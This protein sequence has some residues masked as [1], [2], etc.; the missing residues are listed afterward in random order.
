MVDNPDSGVDSTSSA[1]NLE[2]NIDVEQENYFTKCS[3]GCICMAIRIE[4]G[5][6]AQLLQFYSEGRHKVRLEKLIDR[7]KLLRDGYKAC[8]SI[9]GNKNDKQ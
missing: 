2:G 7:L 1:D 9:K 6:I 5:N 4:L 8:S 3:F